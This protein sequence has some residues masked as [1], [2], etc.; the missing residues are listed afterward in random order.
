MSRREIDRK[1]D[2]IIAFRRSP[3]R[4]HIDRPFAYLFFRHAARLTFSVAIS[5]QPEILIIDEWLAVGDARFSLKC[6]EKIREFRDRG[7]TIV[8]VTH[9][10]DTLLEFCDR[11]VVLD[12]GR[13]VCFGEP[14]RRR[15]SL[16]PYHLRRSA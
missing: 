2:S 4:D 7:V 1:L 12:H 16:S 15:F 8:F 10:Y 5:V 6:Y 11:G 14:V 13:L 3:M 9:N